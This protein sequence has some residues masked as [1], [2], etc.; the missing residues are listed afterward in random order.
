L[1]AVHVSVHQRDRRFDRREIEETILRGI[2]VRSIVGVI[3]GYI[4]MFVLVFVTF[5]CVY[6]LMG[7]EWSF[8][9]N[10][11]EASNR[12]IGMSLVANLVIGIVGGL[13]CAFIARSG[14]APMVLAL[15]VFLLGILLAIPA[16]I[17]HKAN[18]NLVRAGNVS[19][20]EAMQ[21]ANEPI[22]VP[23]T[24]PVIGAI[25]VLIGGRLRK[26]S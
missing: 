5:T 16:V 3:V 24:F 20:M 26:R 8:K 22:W 12:W 19:Q 9:P 4:A 11:F 6:L 7:A 10:S 17:A 2:V 15:V 25:G 1:D 18:A 23:F 13:V 14:K 21:K